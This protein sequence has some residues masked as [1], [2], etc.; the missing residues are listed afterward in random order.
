MLRR[1]NAREAPESTVQREQA[2]AEAA[3]KTDDEEEPQPMCPQVMIGPD[4]QIILNKERCIKV[5]NSF[6]IV[7]FLS[8]IHVLNFGIKL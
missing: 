8:F 6:P 2:I 1:N 3:E 7:Y 5:T 4:G